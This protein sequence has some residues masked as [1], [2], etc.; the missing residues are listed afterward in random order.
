MRGLQRGLVVLLLSAVIRGELAVEGNP[1]ADDHSTASACCPAQRLP[2]E[3]LLPLPTALAT[4][5]D[6]FVK[7]RARLHAGVSVDVFTFR[8]PPRLSHL[9]LPFDLALVADV[10]PTGIIEI[11]APAKDAA[12]S[13]FPDYSWDHWVVCQGTADAAPQH[14][15]WRFTRKPGVTGG[16]ESFV[17]LIVAARDREAEAEATAR[18]RVPVSASSAV[19]EDEVEAGAE[20]LNMHVGVEAPGW[21]VSLMA[22]VTARAAHRSAVPIA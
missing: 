1:H 10:D 21:L 6:T 2:P 15:G 12:D 18:V 11:P 19:R 7:V 4:Q 16:V 22:A 20:A 5:R 17:A 3:T 8:Q 9:E 14:L 13:W